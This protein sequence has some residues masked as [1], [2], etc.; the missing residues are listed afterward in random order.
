MARVTNPTIIS[1]VAQLDTAPKYLIRMAWDAENR[2]ATWGASVSWNGETWVTSG[3]KIRGLSSAGGSLVL[4]NGD[5]DP[6]ASLVLNDGQQGRAISI[7]EHHTDLAASPQTD[8]VRVFAGEMDQAKIGKEVTITFIAAAVVAR[9][10]HT[11]LDETV[12]PYLLKA[13]TVIRLGIDKIKV[14]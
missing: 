8:A 1:A 11:A 5:G 12:Y 9:F 6:W 2:I 4:P 10:P 14:E 7:Y 13:G 3:A